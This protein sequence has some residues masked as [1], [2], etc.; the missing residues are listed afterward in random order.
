MSYCQIPLAIERV[1]DA[2]GRVGGIISEMDDPSDSAQT[3]PED[4]YGRNEHGNFDNL[5]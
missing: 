4:W 5:Y 2:I 3:E 1:K